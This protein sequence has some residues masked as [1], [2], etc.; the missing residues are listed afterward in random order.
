MRY[1]VA[2]T[3]YSS[4][5]PALNCAFEGICQTMIA[6]MAAIMARFKPV[7]S[8]ATGPPNPRRL[9][10]AASTGVTMIA[11]RKRKREYVI[12]A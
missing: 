7:L 12:A 1:I 9:S 6:V 5:I 11:A 3:G 10:S 8:A 4:A 2:A